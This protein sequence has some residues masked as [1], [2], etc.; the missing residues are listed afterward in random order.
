MVFWSNLFTTFVILATGY[1]FLYTLK[2]FSFEIEDLTY[3]REVT[4]AITDY[5]WIYFVYVLTGFVIVM[6]LVFYTWL[7]ISNTIAGPLY[8]IKKTLEEYIETGD[9]RPI[10]LRDN[11]KLTEFADVINK[12]IA[13]KESEKK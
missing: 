11:D 9:F 10:S 3:L 2:R 4:N 12:A 1:L 7:K 8:K 13:R 5:S 6:S